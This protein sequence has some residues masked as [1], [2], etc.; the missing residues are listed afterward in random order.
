MNDYEK[1]RA[2]LATQ[3]G[4]RGTAQFVA[5]LG[6]DRKIAAHAVS[7]M[8]RS[9]ALIRQ[10]TKPYTYT[11]GATPKRK[12][13]TVE[14][15]HDESNRLRAIALRRSKGCVPRAEYEAA[16][17]AK[18]EADK[19]A[20]D[21]LRAQKAAEMVIRKAATKERERIRLKNRV[22][23]SKP[24]PTGKPVFKQSRKLRL[25]ECS[26]VKPVVVAPRLMTSEEWIAMGGKVER[27]AS[28]VVSRPLQFVGFRGSKAA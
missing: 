2:W 3:D 5:A 7:D 12:R 17:K 25:V 1:M 11:L 28:G 26:S 8:Y 24:K 10:P 20:K 19:S 14:E 23:V 13:L 9:G 15:R 27:I 18:R 22:Y 16:C 4:P 21:A 6:I